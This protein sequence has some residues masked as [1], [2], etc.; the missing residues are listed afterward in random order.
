MLQFRVNGLRVDSLRAAGYSLR[1]A[2]YS[3][4]SAG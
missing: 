1:A 4:R 2:G 3:M